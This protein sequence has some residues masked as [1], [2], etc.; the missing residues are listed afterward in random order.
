MSFVNAEQ[1]VSVCFFFVGEGGARD[2]RFDY[3]RAWTLP[4]FFL[5]VLEDQRLVFGVKI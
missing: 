1:L 2:V 3:F 4:I 5:C